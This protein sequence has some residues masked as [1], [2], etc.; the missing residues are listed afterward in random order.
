[1]T[2]L[3]LFDAVYKAVSGLLTVGVVVLLAKIMIQIGSW[4][5]WVKSTDKEMTSH[6]S[7]LQQL[8]AAVNRILGRLEHDDK[9]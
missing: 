9:K 5:E 4:K 6:G 7:M 3:D 8:T 1:M 2:N